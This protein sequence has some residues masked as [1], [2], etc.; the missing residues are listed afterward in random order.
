M[1]GEGIINKKNTNLNRV[2]ISFLPPKGQEW[3]C[4]T[5]PIH[6]HFQ[7]Q[8]TLLISCSQKPSEPHNSRSN[9]SNSEGR[10][11]C[12][13]KRGQKWARPHLGQHFSFLIPSLD[14][15]GCGTMLI[16]KSGAVPAMIKGEWYAWRRADPAGCVCWQTASLSDSSDEK[17]QSHGPVQR[18]SHTYGRKHTA[19]THLSVDRSGLSPLTPESGTLA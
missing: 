8:A 11:C 2:H 16:M 4:W 15:R 14:F 10:G 9:I 6:L 3:D 1:I 7:V 17:T 13:N 12:G 5:C 19:Y 18:G